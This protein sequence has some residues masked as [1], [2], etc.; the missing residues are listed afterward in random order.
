MEIKKSEL[1]ELVKNQVIKESK[2]VELEN[3]IKAIEKELSLLNEDVSTQNV[4]MPTAAPTNYSQA[5]AEQEE[6]ESIFDAKPGEIIIFNFRDVT[7]KAQRQLDDL[8]KITDAAESKKL[9]EGDY[10]KV[11]GNDL[12]MKGKQIKFVILREALRYESNP[13]SSWRIIKNR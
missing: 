8:F 10:V 11:Q 6:S 1:A 7:V 12:L 3:K 2:K 5:P 13:L 4:A 9:K